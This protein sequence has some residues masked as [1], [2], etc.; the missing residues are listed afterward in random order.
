MVLDDGGGGKK[1]LNGGGDIR[2]FNIAT[3]DRVVRD[4]SS[5][6]TA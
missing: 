6:S 2:V 1:S 5:L 3:I 4:E